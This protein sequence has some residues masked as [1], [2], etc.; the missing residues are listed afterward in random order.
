MKKKN[1]AIILG[2]LSVLFSPLM[3][4]V[5]Q[6]NDV[7]LNVET[8]SFYG[9]N[10]PSGDAWSFLRYHNDGGPRR[11][12]PPTS[13]PGHIVGPGSRF[14]YTY[15]VTHQSGTLS[16]ATYGVTRVEG[17]VRIE[18]VQCPGGDHNYYI[19]ATPGDPLSQ[20]VVC[21]LPAGWESRA[22]QYITITASTDN[23]CHL[24]HRGN[25]FGGESPRD[26]YGNSIYL[27][28]YAWL[29]SDWNVNSSSSGYAWYNVYNECALPYPWSDG[30]REESRFWLWQ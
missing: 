24:Y 20:Y 8:V 21:L 3:E 16:G 23:P 2:A 12:Q 19:S 22:P 11:D 18:N 15:S 10:N 29:E 26:N 30:Y 9:P 14:T 25:P 5:A 28:S 7:N 27:I 4:K 13:R 1:V 6:A 17:P